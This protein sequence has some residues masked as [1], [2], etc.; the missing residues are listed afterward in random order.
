LGND[1]FAK[2]FAE[3]DHDSSEGKW[4]DMYGFDEK[5]SYYFESDE[6]KNESEI[7]GI[8]VEDGLE[9]AEIVDYEIEDINWV[10]TGSGYMRMSLDDILIPNR[11][12]IK[13]TSVVATD[14]F[15]NTYESSA[16]FL[17]YENEDGEEIANG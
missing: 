7:I 6:F 3:W 5:I 11:E 14:N 12:D 4:K 15:G 8:D 16:Y 9:D 2:E 1:T 17:H 10:V 13:I